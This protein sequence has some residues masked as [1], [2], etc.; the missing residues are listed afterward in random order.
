MNIFHDL[1]SYNFNYHNLRLDLT[2]KLILR[3][4][5]EKQFLQFVEFIREQLKTDLENNQVETSEYN[6][7]KGIFSDNPLEHCLINHY[8]QPK[9]G[10]I[11]TNKYNSSGLINYLI[12]IGFTARPDFIEEQVRLYDPTIRIDPHDYYLMKFKK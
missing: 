8:I 3:D 6:W 4:T 2:T 12:T 11:V 1:D 7:V 10:P 9:K 5:I